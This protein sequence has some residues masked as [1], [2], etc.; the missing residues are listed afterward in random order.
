M[1][2]FLT[3]LYATFVKINSVA[4]GTA[5]NQTDSNTKAQWEVWSMSG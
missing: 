4:D 5:K 1:M 2:S 3:Y